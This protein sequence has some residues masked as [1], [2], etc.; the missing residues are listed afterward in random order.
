MRGRSYVVG[1]VVPL[2]LIISA[3]SAPQ[4]SAEQR[5]YTC[6]ESALEKTFSD[7]HCVSAGGSSYGHVLIGA[8][9]EIFGTNAKTASGTTAATPGV[10]KA[11]VSGVVV[12]IS[13]EEVHFAGSLVNTATAFVAEIPAVLG[14]GCVVKKPAGKGCV[15][16]TE[17]I[18]ES[19]PLY[20]TSKG[21]KANKVEILPQEGETIAKIKI[22]KCTLVALNNTYSLNGFFVVSASGATLTST[23]PEV[24]AQNTLKLAGVNAGFE[25]ALTASMEAGGGPAITVT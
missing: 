23:H 2:I 21:Q 10:L 12:E 22:A 18:I 17:E 8:K 15:V 19:E 4:A 1:T 24:T 6:S 13:C 14:T 11:A 3:I 5:A 25:G 9:T 20:A 16:G 7:A